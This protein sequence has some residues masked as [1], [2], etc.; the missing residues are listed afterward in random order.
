M[1]LNLSRRNFL[2]SATAGLAGLVL[3][4]NSSA[5]AQQPQFNPDNYR[6]NYE[7]WVEA[8]EAYR[9]AIKARGNE[10]KILVNKFRNSKLFTKVN[11][12]C[13]EPRKAYNVLSNEDKKGINDLYKIHQEYTNRISGNKNKN[14]PSPEIG[15]ILV[16]PVTEGILLP[17]DIAKMVM[18]SGDKAYLKDFYGRDIDTNKGNL[19][20]QDSII[21]YLD[22]KFTIQ[23]NKEHYQKIEERRAKMTPEELELDKDKGAKEGAK[24]VFNFF[25]PNFFN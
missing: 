1:A 9:A 25:F 16:S 19:S 24:K 3:S 6:I 11:E 13:N 12:I 7:E 18:S 20:L 5:E 14:R 15:D 23:N 2:K 10:K 21:I 8:K 22:K 17:L 4:T